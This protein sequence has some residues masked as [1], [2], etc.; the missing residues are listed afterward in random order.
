MNEYGVNLRGLISIMDPQTG[1]AVP[2]PAS[3]KAP[4]K[5]KVYKNPNTGEVV[6][7]KGGNRKVL[8]AR[9]TEFGAEVVEDWLQ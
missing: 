9:K 6:E 5:L 8:K 4:R 1:A 2:R 3:T 7:A